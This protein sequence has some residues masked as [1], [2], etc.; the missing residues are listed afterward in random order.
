MRARAHIYIY[1]AVARIH[2]VSGRVQR[3]ISK[4]VADGEEFL[5]L[6][7]PLRRSANERLCPVTSKGA[8]PT[9]SK[10]DL[11]IWSLLCFQRSASKNDL[12][13]RSLKVLRSYGLSS[14]GDLVG[15]ASVSAKTLNG[16]FSVVREWISLK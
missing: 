2:S 15:V 3:V 10:D 6:R 8:P 5:R 11:Q 16:F 9:T 13:I 12:Q 1:T 4:G 7:Q 14:K